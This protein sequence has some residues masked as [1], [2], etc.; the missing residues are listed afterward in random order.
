MEFFRHMYS[1]YIFCSHDVNIL[2]TVSTKFIFYTTWKFQPF[3][4]DQFVSLIV[5][6]LT[7]EV[8]TINIIKYTYYSD[9]I[10]FV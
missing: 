9:T 7:N 10:R 3:E 6:R 1:V 5:K 4:E 2:A 8:N